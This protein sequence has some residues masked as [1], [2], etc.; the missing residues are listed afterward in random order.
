MRIVGGTFKGRIFNPGK[1]FSARPTTDFSK[2]NLFNI[3]ENRIDW[4]QSE[5]LDLFSGTGSI[6]YEMISRGCKNVTAVEINSRHVRFISVTKSTLG[7]Q[8]L[9]I[10]REEAFRFISKAKKQYDLIFVDPPYDMRNF[11]EV[12]VKVFEA[13]LLREGGLF[14]LEHNKFQNFKHLPQ[15]QELRTYGSVN[16]SFF[17]S[18]IPVSE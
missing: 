13:G 16:F 9:H 10:V 3:L 15:F 7:I 11:A 2:E 18:I 17:K 6:S 1:N 8:N 5:A 12:P 4:E 14:I